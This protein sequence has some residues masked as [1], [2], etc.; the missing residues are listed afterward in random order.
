MPPGKEKK[1]IRPVIEEVASGPVGE[2]QQTQEE[3]GAEQVTPEAV[4]PK[5]EISPEE[6]ARE[7]ISDK[8]SAGDSPSGKTD[9]KL[10]LLVTVISA[11]VVGFVAGGVYVYF[12]GLSQIEE[13]VLKPTQAPQVLSPTPTPQEPSPSPIPG[14]E[15][16]V[17]SYKVSVLNGS[18]QIGAAG[19]V[20]SLLEE[21]G[22]EIANIGN[23]TKYDYEA[24]VIQAKETVPEQVL[25]MIEDALSDTYS[26]EMGDALLSTS[27]YDIIVTVGTE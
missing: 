19:S 4:E 22:F 26:V 25:Q 13:S 10:I 23:A 1:R 6:K 12:T 18:G 15:I 5:E 2:T 14:E 3:K 24:T 17:S 27:G 9:Y 8:H 16:D 11:V 21:A 20:G 7:I